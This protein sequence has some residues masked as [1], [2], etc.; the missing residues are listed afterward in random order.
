[1]VGGRRLLDEHVERGACYLAGFQRVGERSFIDDSAARAVDDSHSLLHLRERRRAD[2][3][4]RVVGQRSVHGDEV[5]VREKLV[6]AD[7]LNADATGSISGQNRIV[8]DHFHLEPDRAVRDD[9]PDVTEANDAERL[10]ADLGAG[11]FAAIPFSGMNRSV[12]CRDVPRQRH[13]HRDRMLGSRDAVAG[14][15]V[16]HDDSATRRRFDIDVVNAD[17]RAP[18]HFERRG[19]VDYFAG[20]ASAAAN[21]QRVVGRDYF[22]QLFRLESGLDVDL[23]LREAL[24]DFDPLRRKRVA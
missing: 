19:R 13:H 22:R 15:A 1:M 18:D 17:A 24:E 11:E 16:H 14:R 9:A 7:Q 5:G 23:Q 20:D 6:E 4:P 2:D 3:A 8:A 21:Q 10:V 12:G